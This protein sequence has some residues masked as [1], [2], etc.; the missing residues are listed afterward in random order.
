V[1]PTQPGKTLPHTAPNKGSTYS[2]PP[3][4]QE[5]DETPL[6]SDS[7]V[8]RLRLVGPAN[9]GLGTT[10]AVADRQGFPTKGLLGS[11]P[12]TAEWLKRTRG[13]SAPKQ[14]EELANRKR[15]QAESSH[16]GH[17]GYHSSRIERA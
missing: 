8:E 17:G 4:G 16:Y 6:V 15:Q 3:V 14:C 9:G 5:A 10:V 1:L 7:N 12:T 11:R 13:S 2:G